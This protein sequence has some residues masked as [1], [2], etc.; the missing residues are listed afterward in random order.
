VSSRKEPVE[1]LQLFR[2]NRP[3]EVERAIVEARPEDYVASS[4]QVV[5]LAP[6]ILA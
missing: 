2:A 1:I 5:Q 4:F 3:A 6:K